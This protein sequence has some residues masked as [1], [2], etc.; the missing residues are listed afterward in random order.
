MGIERSASLCSVAVLVDELVAWLQQDALPLWDQYGVDREMGG[1]FESLRVVSN[2]R[3]FE[4]SGR[5]RRGRVVSRQMFAFDVGHRLG[6]KSMYSDPVEHGCDYLFSRMHRGD[7][8]FHTSL[9]AETG[10]PQS[11]FSL[12]EYAFY[13]FALARVS[14][15]Q[16]AHFPIED[17]AALCLKQLRRNWGKVIGGFEE[18]E[19]SRLPLKSNP[20]MHLFEAALAWI[21]ASE[22]SRAA[23]WVEL[24]EEIAE[25]CTG[26][27]IDA[28]TGL[29]REYFDAQWRPMEGDSGRVVEPGHQF[30]WAWL[31]VRWVESG[32][33]GSRHREMCL[34]AARRLV[35]VGERWGVDA[36]RGVAVN[37]LR[38]DMC[39][40]D[41]AAKLWPQTE[42]IKAWCAMLEQAQTVNDA[43]AARHKLTLAI[44][45][46]LQYFLVQPRGLWQEVMLP[47]GDFTSEPCKAS[48]FYHIVCA[49]ET[50]Q[51]SLVVRGNAM[52]S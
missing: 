34:A 38:D 23:P 6:W 31:L 28:D 33:G 10:L 15:A 1:Y 51:R 5:I 41:P 50:L 26:Y 17:T 9:D 24:A 27:F 49:I 19:P 7:G 44:R 18:G 4:I 42:R 11:L 48:S 13:L 43:E 2:T 35:E 12:Y 25:L 20:H 22:G 40:T 36:A 39:I 30:E 46:M 21:E 47:G 45:G 32:H 52:R 8:L 14:A 29:I 16:S 37:E 3:A